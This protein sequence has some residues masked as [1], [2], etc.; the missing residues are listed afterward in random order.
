MHGA[1]S[2]SLDMPSR[3][4]TLRR[5]MTDIGKNIS[6]KVFRSWRGLYNTQRAYFFLQWSILHKL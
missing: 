5:R 3:P 4:N 2:S 6:I 1:I